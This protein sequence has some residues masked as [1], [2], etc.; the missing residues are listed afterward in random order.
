MSKDS[1]IDNNQQRKGSMKKT[2]KEMSKTTMPTETT[3]T[4]ER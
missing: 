4:T 3:I 1:Q 2:T